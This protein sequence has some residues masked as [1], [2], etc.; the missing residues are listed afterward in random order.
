[1]GFRAG[2]SYEFKGSLVSR[3][4]SRRA[5]ATPVSMLPHPPPKKKKKKR[6]EKKEI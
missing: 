3:T 1:L 2:R 5:R 4:S 6:K